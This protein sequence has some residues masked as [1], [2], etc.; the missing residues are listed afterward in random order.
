VVNGA[1]EEGAKLA[2]AA[3]L[4][5]FPR[6][7]QR[8]HR[9]LHLPKLAVKPFLQLRH[10]DVRHMAIVE[11]CERQAKLGAELFQ[12][13]LRLP[14]LRQDIVRRLPDRR[15]I[16]HQRARPIE[17][18]VPNHAASVVVFSAAAT[19]SSKQAQIA[20]PP[21]SPRA[22]ALNL[23]AFAREGFLRLPLKFIAQLPPEPARVFRPQQHE[24]A[25]LIALRPDPPF[26]FQAPKPGE[27]L[28]KLLT[29]SRFQPG[30]VVAFRGPLAR[31]LPLPLAQLGQG[32][33]LFLPLAQ[34]HAA[35]DKIAAFH[36]NRKVWASHNGG[37]LAKRA[38]LL[39]DHSFT[40][41]G[42]EANHDLPE[43]KGQPESAL[44]NRLPLRYAPAARG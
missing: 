26:V 39:R 27:R 37:G 22:L 17:D 44:P 24:K 25:G 31:R 11:N 14:R 30:I 35:A 2:R 42:D 16:V 36:R 8:A 9:S 20:I 10:R 23:P 32:A 34:F 38:A 5:K 29:E 12:A 3:K 41:S 19:P 15:Q 18:D 28:Q 43:K 4:Q 33:P 13:H 1:K 21:A 7:R 6:M 40:V